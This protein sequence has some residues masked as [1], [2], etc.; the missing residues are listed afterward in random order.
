MLASF[1]QIFD[2]ESHLVIF[3]A[4]MGLDSPSVGSAVLYANPIPNAILLPERGFARRHGGG[5]SGVLE[6]RWA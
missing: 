6:L 2:G 1:E 4:S 3:I 5:G